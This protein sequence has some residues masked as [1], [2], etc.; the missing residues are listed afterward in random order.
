MADRTPTWRVNFSI[1]TLRID[2]SEGGRVNIGMA[3]APP[4]QQ[5]A[6]T[7]GAR[8]EADGKR[9]STVAVGTK[10]A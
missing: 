5:Q 6:T 9:S 2:D 3:V 1:R 10:R 8:R 7:T 4:R